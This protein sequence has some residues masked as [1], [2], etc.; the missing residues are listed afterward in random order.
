MS[1][2]SYSDLQTAIAN[3]LA[4]VGD[5]NITSNAADFITLCEA[6]LAYGSGDKEDPDATLYTAP[7]RIRAMETTRVV[8]INAVVSGVPVGGTANAITLTP[9]PAIS[10]Y[11]AGQTWN[12]TASAANTGTVAVNISGQGNRN[13]LKGSGLSQLAA[14]DIVGG[15]LVQMYDDGTELVYMPGTANAP[16]PANYLAMRALYLDTNPRDPL[17]YVTPPQANLRF[18]S[19]WPS[20]PAFYTIEGDAIRLEPSPDTAY[21][22]VIAYYQ[23]FGTLSSAT[24]W[25]MTN[26]PNVYLYGALLEAAIF[27]QMDDE[28]ARYLRLFRAACNGIQMQDVHDRHSGGLL[29]IR[30]DSGNP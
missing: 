13:L 19:Q 30:N 16:L 5:T 1:L 10:A 12:F 27:L 6:R 20:Q 15:Q 2:A 21:N 17:E 4:R 18:N 28:V 14:G 23:K 22:L 11:A 25:L 9:S 24:N 8:P 26:A 3:W 7:L 29:T